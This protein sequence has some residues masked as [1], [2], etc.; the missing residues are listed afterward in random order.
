MRATNNATNDKDD[1]DDDDDSR[2]PPSRAI[3]PPLGDGRL[4]T[5]FQPPFLEGANHGGGCVAG[6]RWFVVRRL[7]IWNWRGARAKI[8]AFV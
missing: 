8:G 7:G 1:D 4:G 5:V 2:N 3:P 6:C